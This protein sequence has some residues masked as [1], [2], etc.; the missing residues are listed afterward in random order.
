MS[1]YIQILCNCPNQSTANNIANELIELKLAACVNI[2]P[3]VTSVYRWQGK[4][5]QET[6]VQLQIKTTMELYQSVEEQLLML[7]PYDVP[8]VIALPIINAHQPYL[9]W[10]KQ[11]TKAL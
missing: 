8:E 2:L 1:Q 6:E 10:I 9:D 11:N 5:E 7:H 3:A 4:L